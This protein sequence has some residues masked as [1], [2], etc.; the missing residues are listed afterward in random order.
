MNTIRS[1]SRRAVFALSCF[2]ALAL[3]LAPTAHAGIAGRT[4]LVE[5]TGAGNYLNVDVGSRFA[6]MQTQAAGADV[7]AFDLTAPTPVEVPVAVSAADE[8][9][10]AV[11]GSR[12]VYLKRRDFGTHELMLETIPPSGPIGQIINEWE[13]ADPAL[14]DDQC[15]YALDTDWDGDFGVYRWDIG[16]GQHSTV[17][18]PTLDGASARQ[19][20]IW[21][22][23]IAYQIVSPFAGD[24]DVFYEPLDGRWTVFPYVPDRTGDRV[25]PAVWGEWIVWEDHSSADGDI[26]AYNVLTREP[27]VIGHDGAVDGNPSVYDDRVVYTSVAND[28][29]SAHV[30]AYDLSTGVESEIWTRSGILFFGTTSQSGSD[31][32]WSEFVADSDARIARLD[33]ALDAEQ[34]EGPTR[35]ETAVEI[36]QALSP[37][38]CD[39]VLV[40]TGENFPDAL[41]GAAL[42]GALD[43]PILLTRP[44]ALPAAVAAEIERLQPKAVYILGGI[45]AVGDAVQAQI[46]AIVPLA[47]ITRLEGD[48]RYGTAR[49]VANEVWMHPRQEFGGT[50]LVATGANFPD[51]L[52]ASPVAAALQMPIYLAEPSGISLTDIAHMQERDIDE[53]YILGG[54]DVVSEET[55]ERLTDAFGTDSVHRIEGPTRYETAAEIAEW[56][57]EELPWIEYCGVTLATG[58]NFPDALAGGAL[59][60]ARGTVMLLTHTASLTPTTRTVLEST[61]VGTP[62]VTF[63]GGEGALEPEVV[64]EVTALLQ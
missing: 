9:E 13:Y 44:A 12:C 37:G 33:V 28:M 43:C 41:G 32:G 49:A 50:A 15:V 18:Q 3:L 53:V 39:S 22:N 5:K 10:P 59:A 51:A 6:V 55:E 23:I 54:S 47:T 14:W 31:V 17:Y 27:T 4:F 8:M 48:D 40:A 35:Y 63:F 38:T 34:L 26:V 60:G 42:A 61:C 30:Y 46:Q 52:A 16:T 7:V 11:W 29:S 24:T 62:R 21:R 56:A 20:D 64:N 1:S 25:L 2:A 36:S 19:P 57:V 58:Q 45:G